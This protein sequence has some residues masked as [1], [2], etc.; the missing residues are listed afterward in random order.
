MRH[1]LLLEHTRIRVDQLHA[2]VY[3]FWRAIDFL[4]ANTV[5]AVAHYSTNNSDQPL[6]IEVHSVDLI[7]SNLSKVQ[8]SDEAHCF[9]TVASND[10]RRS[11]QSLSG[12]QFCIQGI[13]TSHAFK[14][15]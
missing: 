5:T 12:R 9:S 3:T 11:I 2:D 1:I 14:G 8:Q 15:D 7:D 4:D 10:Q 6:T 13:I